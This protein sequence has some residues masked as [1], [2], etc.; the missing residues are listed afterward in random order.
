MFKFAIKKGRK[1]SA[2]EIVK[3]I[4][5]AFDTAADR[6][7][8]EAKNQI[9]L[10]ESKDLSN[11]QITDKARR[12]ANLGFVD[13]TIVKQGTRIL[14]L[15]EQQKKD[16]KRKQV[17]SQVVQH[18]I[19]RYPFLKFLTVEELDLI[20]AKYNL[21]YAPVEFYR[22]DVPEK[23]LI[24]IE[25]APPLRSDETVPN[26]IMLKITSLYTSDKDLLKIL[27][28]KPFLYG[29]TKDYSEHNDTDWIVNTYARSKGYKGE[30]GESYISRKCERTELHMGGLFMAAPKSEFS[31]LSKF[32]QE[33]EFGYAN[34][35]KT[36]VDDP[37][38]FRYCRGGIQVV[39]KWGP[40]ASD[41]LLLNPLEN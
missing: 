37:I 33:N 32:I 10:L 40:E 22:G 24:E 28:D 41:P 23:N 16:I 26:K 7:L 4:H 13:S 5:E 14:T 21:I 3:E 34:S 31:D 35:T 20:C 29:G 6:L 19:N 11:S 30:F 36:I 15:L 18:Y 9:K 27:L 39:T 1:K 25:N 12:L 38:V 2:A 8:Q 17:V